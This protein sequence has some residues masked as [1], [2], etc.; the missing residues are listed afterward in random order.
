MMPKA[1][2]EKLN[3]ARTARLVAVV[4][5]ALIGLT[6]CKK[7]EGFVFKPEFTVN[8]FYPGPKWPNQKKLS[9]AEREV[10]QRYGRPAAF[11]IL[12]SPAG[13][14]RMRSE[15]EDASLKQPKVMPAYSWVYPGLNKEIVFT[16]GTYQER[17]L[18]DKIRLIL[19]YGDPEDVKDLS[20]GIEQWTYYGVGKMI[21]LREGHIVEEKQFPAMGRFLKN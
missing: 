11:R 13:E 7:D 5:A 14:I 4:A 19:R 15:L 3:L 6:A 2:S 18:S 1:P 9:K 20:S 8:L 10:L 21:K 12:W 16:Q 17:Q